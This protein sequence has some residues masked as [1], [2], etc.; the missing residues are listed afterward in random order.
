MYKSR[1]RYARVNAELLGWLIFLAAFFLIVLASP[2][3]HFATIEWTKPT[4]VL[5][6]ERVNTKDESKYII[7]T[8]SEVFENTDSFLS[9]KW[10]SSDLYRD[11]KVGESCSFKVTGFRVPFLSWYRNILESKCSPVAVN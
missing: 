2:I 4:V 5:E 6:K 1:R 9:L 3:A 7:F 10:D 11:I 8:E